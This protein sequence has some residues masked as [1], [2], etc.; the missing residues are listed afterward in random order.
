MKIKVDH[1]V[2]NTVIWAARNRNGG[3]AH[4]S[5]NAPRGGM[6]NVQREYMDEYEQDTLDALLLD[7]NG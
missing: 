2:R 3:G 4:K 1:T 5:R 7:S 6:R